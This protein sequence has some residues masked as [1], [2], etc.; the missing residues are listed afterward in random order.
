MRRVWCEGGGAGVGVLR[1]G[2]GVLG[3]LGVLG[4]DSRQRDLSAVVIMEPRSGGRG[5]SG[6]KYW[7]PVGCSSGYYGDRWRRASGPGGRGRGRLRRHD[8]TPEAPTT[9]G[10]VSST[11]RDETRQKKGRKKRERKRA[12]EAGAIRATIGRLSCPGPVFPPSPSQSQG[13]PAADTTTVWHF[14]GL[15]QQRA[16]ERLVSPGVRRREERRERE[17]RGTRGREYE[18]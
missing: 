6:A 7:I 10:C 18:R 2:L 15:V 8:R 13:L 12:R 14:G 3:V 4:E 5:I 1:G 11:R 16:G 17:V 9:P